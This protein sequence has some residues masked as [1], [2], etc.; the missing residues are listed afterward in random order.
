[1]RPL[2]QHQAYNIH[3]WGSQRR[4]EIKGAEAYLKM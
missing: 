4:K 3:L 1:M 2:G